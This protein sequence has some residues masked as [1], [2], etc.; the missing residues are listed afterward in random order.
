MSP[1]GINAHDATVAAVPA[2]ARAD[3]MDAPTEQPALLISN[4]DLGVVIEGDPET[5]AARLR[6]LLGQVQALAGPLARL[7]IVDDPTHVSDSS[8]DRWLMTLGSMQAYRLSIVQP[9]PEHGVGCAHDTVLAT[10]GGIVADVGHTGVYTQPIDVEHPQLRRVAAGMDT[11]GRLPGHTC[12]TCREPIC[13]AGGQWVDGDGDA[14]CEGH[15]DACQAGA[16]H[17]HQPRR[18]EVPADHKPTQPGINACISHVHL[19]VLDR[20]E[21]GDHTHRPRQPGGTP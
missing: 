5:L 12:R 10:L 4:G 15:G 3:W 8:S 16:P 6:D 19:I 18:E 7:V 14:H 11:G 17:H 2:G 21:I 20:R 1:V 9:C 13:Q